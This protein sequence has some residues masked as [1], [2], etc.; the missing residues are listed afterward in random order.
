M[1]KS[2]L[3]RRQLS[4]DGLFAIIFFKK[5]CTFDLINSGM[6]VKRTTENKQFVKNEY[7]CVE[8]L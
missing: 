3:I 5:N 1:C 4:F 8:N 2:N 7:K 6:S